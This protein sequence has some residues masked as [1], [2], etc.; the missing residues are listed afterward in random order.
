VFFLLGLFL[1]CIYTAVS[2]F[3]SSPSAGRQ[4]C[5]LCSIFLCPFICDVVTAQYLPYGLI[6]QIFTKLLPVVHL[7][8]RWIHW[9]GLALETQ[10]GHRPRSEDQ[11]E[12]HT[13]RWVLTL[14]LF[15]AFGNRQYRTL[16]SN[17]GLLLH[18]LLQ[19]IRAACLQKYQC[20]TISLFSDNRMLDHVL[21][22]FI[23]FSVFNYIH[24]YAYSTMFWSLFIC[25]F[26]DLFICMLNY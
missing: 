1:S 23:A 6:W 4:S 21:F 5:M 13:V 7:G 2:H 10:K 25:F 12:R 11:L 14:W 15:I 20:I 22:V 19:M 16:V 26:V 3:L 9:T 18:L 8:I 24:E 17:I